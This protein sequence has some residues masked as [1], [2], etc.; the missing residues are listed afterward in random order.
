MMKSLSRVL[1][2]LKLTELNSLRDELEVLISKKDSIKGWLTFDKLF[3]F[4]IR[5]ITKQELWDILKD[6]PS[7]S[8]TSLHSLVEGHIL[9][10]RMAE[11]LIK[12]KVVVTKPDGEDSL[13]KSSTEEMIAKAKKEIILLGYTYSS[14]GDFKKLLFQANKRGVKI[15]IIGQSKFVEAMRKDLKHANGPGKLEFY[16][17]DKNRAGEIIAEKKHE[18]YG[19]PKFHAKVI[20]VDQID[21]IISSANLT[22][23]GMTCNVEIGTIVKRNEIKEVIKFLREIASKGIIYRYSNWY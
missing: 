21:G 22:V 23:S 11:E 9:E 19:Y 20:I 15:L 16:A 17:F 6:G 7:C 8:L 10:R 12:K 2:R 13:I 4:D 3:T 18:D 14:F 1:L 5:G